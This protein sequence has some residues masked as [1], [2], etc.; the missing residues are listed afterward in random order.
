[1]YIVS[2]PDP[3]LFLQGDHALEEAYR[4]AELEGEEAMAM[5]PREWLHQTPLFK[6]M[7]LGLPI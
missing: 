4:L 5:K 2:M 7:S 3:G 1:M 6:R